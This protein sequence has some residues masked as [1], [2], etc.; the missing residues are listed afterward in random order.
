MSYK[1]AKKTKTV[2]LLIITSLIVEL[3]IFVGFVAG[4]LLRAGVDMSANKESIRIAV[5]S[6]PNNQMLIFGIIF[7]FIAVF[8]AT[9]FNFAISKNILEYLKNKRLISFGESVKFASSRLLDIT[10]WSL[11]LMTVNI[12][13]QIL[14][15]IAE[16]LGFV[17]EIIMKIINGLL[18]VAWNLLTLFVVPI[19][20][21]N[22]GESVLKVMKKSKD[23]FVNTWGETVVA[24]ASVGVFSFLFILGTAISM[25]IL[26]FITEAFAYA[27]VFLIIFVLVVLVVLVFTS[28]MDRIYKI[29]LYLYAESR[30]IPD[31]IEN[32]ELIEKSFVQKKSKKN[33]KNFKREI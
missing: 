2:W 16:K 6:I 5:E 7:S 17:G 15:S 8:V 1:I 27:W 4:L 11:V 3:F 23:I 19:Y 31:M 30:T 12:I 14:N 28:A 33:K 13:F 26:V 21:E 18:G 25:A 29:I 9:F 32:K 10:I 20:V 24:A 22:K